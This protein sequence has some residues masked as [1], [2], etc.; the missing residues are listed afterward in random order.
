MNTQPDN[1]TEARSNAT[2]THVVEIA[3]RLQRTRG[4]EHSAQ[5]LTAYGVSFSLTVRVLYDPGRRRLIRTTGLNNVT[6]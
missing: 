2:M 6:S 5:F 1:A 4:R 3:L